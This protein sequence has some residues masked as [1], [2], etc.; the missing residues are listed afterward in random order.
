MASS[1]LTLQAKGISKS[2][3][4]VPVLNDVSLEIPAGHVVALAGENGAGKSTI[5]KIIAGLVKADVGHVFVSGK[6]LPNGDTKAAKMAGIAIIPQELSPYPDM[7]IYENLFVGREIHNKLG[8]LNRR[9]MKVQAMKMLEIFGIQIDPATKMRE[10]SVALVQLI[11]IVK[12]SSLGAK[13]LLL[14]EPT[15]SISE[16]EVKV[17]YDVIKRLRAQ[18]VAMI[19]TT[20]RMEEIQEVADSVVVLRDGKCVLATPIANADETTIVTAMVGRE[21]AKLTFESA[22]STDVVRLRVQG[23]KIDKNT[24]EVDF[25]IKRGEILGLGGLMGAGRTEIVEAIFGVRKTIAGQISVDGVSIERGD[26]AKSIKAGCAFVPEDRKG[27]GLILIRSIIENVSLPHLE[28]FVSLG[29][30]NFS[31][32]FD[33]STKV[34]NSV[35]LQSKS[36]SQQVTTLSGGNQQKLVLA[37]WLLK[38]TK[39]LIVDELTRGV[40]VGARAEIYSIIRNL[41]SAGMA[42]LLVSSDMPELIGLSDRVLVIRGGGVVKEMN[43]NDLDSKEAQIEIFRAASAQS[44]FTTEA[45]KVK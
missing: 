26:A 38:D 13:L 2:F 43:R 31:G 6:E 34:T 36:M 12:A 44:L 5:M 29:F 42:V 15:S 1:T 22:V 27:A 41:A 32:R 33:E 21:L 39:V 8:F 28:K 20:H 4:G 10:L 16:K 7:S 14:D 17:L 3:G 23:L 24:P 18:G 19:Y 37:K 25:E 40:D 35:K 45:I 30:I 11:E 9:E